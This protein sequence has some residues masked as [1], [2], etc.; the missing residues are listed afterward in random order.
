MSNNIYSISQD[1][2]KKCIFD[3]E[4]ITEKKRPFTRLVF[5]K[6]FK[7]AR[8]WLKQK[9]KELN[10]S[11]KVDFAGNLV[12]TLK[13]KNKLSKK[14]MIGSHI[15]TVVSGGRFDGV[16]GIVSGLAIVKSI[17]ENNCE[18][19][20][21]LEIYD[22]LGEEL[23]DWNISCIGSRAL[24]GF[25]DEKSLNSK[26]SK[27]DILRD[28]IDKFGGNSAQIGKVS[29]EFKRVIA[30]FELHIEQG[31][32]LENKKVDIGVVQSM[33]NIS[34]HKIIIKGQAGHSGTTLMSNRKDAL[35]TASKLIVY[36]NKLAKE[37]SKKDDRHF[38][39]TVGKIYLKPN[40]VTIIPSEVNFVIDLRVVNQTTKKIFLDKIKEEILRLEKIDN[41]KILFDDLM[42]SP[43]V[44]MSKQLNRCI[45]DCSKKLNYKF[46]CM[47]S[48]AGH[49]T[50]HL[51]KVSEAT[52]VFIPCKDGLSHCP[53]EF[54]ESIYIKRGSEVIFKSILELKNKHLN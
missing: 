33:P 29:D 23:N 48:G 4:A 7:D 31:T 43:Y 38:V 15:D 16:A 8:L 53:E 39:A 34:R 24:C 54:T 27:G 2:I 6:E 17:N 35:V 47:D 36:I 12:G 20:F 42:F 10:L 37:Y 3:L 22:Y 50:A 44:E 46:I 51:S 14:V 32:T 52:I 25:L 26:N 11:T 18:L 13:S 19:P 1:Y 49:D 9:F 41:L 5:S 45:I 28:E 30:C 40:Y 21:D